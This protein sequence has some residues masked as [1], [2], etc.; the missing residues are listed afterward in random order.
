MPGVPARSHALRLAP[1]IALLALLCGLRAAPARA[2]SP[3]RPQ[4]VIVQSGDTLSG[5]AVRFYGSPAAVERIRAANNLADP[6]RI[7]AGSTL[8]LPPA[9]DATASGTGNPARRVT[10][11]PGETL[12]AIAAREYGSAAYAPA[13]A[14][15][16]GITDPDRVLAG[17]TLILPAQPLTPSPSP[18]RGRGVPEGR[19]EGPLAGRRICLD[20]GHGGAV[21]PGAVFDFGDGRVLREADVVLD[22]ARTLRAWLQADGASVTL[23]RA[24]DRYLSLD[25]RAALCNS[26]GADITVSLHLN[27]GDDPAWNG[28]LTLFAKLIDRRLAE[29]LA[30]ALQNGLGRT[31]PGRPFYAFGARPFDGHVLLRTFMPAV[32]VEPVF[33][34]NPAEARALLAPTSQPDSRRNQIVLETYRGIRMYFAGQGGR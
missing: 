14:A 34:T 21:E 30:M 26:A 2:Q 13:L 11:A 10:V 6:D 4:Q 8:V 5:I 28:A 24:E 23:T 29:V 7:L 15:A 20:P 19:G 33:L 3:G 32:I 16:N 18:A 17:T 22:I 1:V 27:G 12:W 31:A 25:E 9:D